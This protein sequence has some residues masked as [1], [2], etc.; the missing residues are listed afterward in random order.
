LSAAFAPILTMRPAADL[1]KYG[2]AERDA[3][4]GNCSITRG[5]S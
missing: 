5:N 2:A 1:A 3:F 4:T